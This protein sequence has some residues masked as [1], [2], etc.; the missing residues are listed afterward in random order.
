MN[1][2]FIGVGNMG[3]PMAANLL[4]AGHTMKVTD[5]RREAAKNLEEAGATWANTAKEATKSEHSVRRRRSLDDCSNAENN[6]N[7]AQRPFAAD[8]VGKPGHEEA[9]QKGTKLQHGSHE[10]LVESIVDLGVLRLELWH[11]V[12]DGNYTLVISGRISE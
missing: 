5:L 4:K 2:G 3:N 11:H 1:V 12:D 9:S 8:F 10:A 7:Y 6:H